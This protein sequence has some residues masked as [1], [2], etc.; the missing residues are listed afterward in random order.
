MTVYCKKSVGY[1]HLKNDPSVRHNL[2]TGDDLSPDSA[3]SNSLRQ[4]N[5]VNSNPKL[6][7]N[8]ASN[9]LNLLKAYLQSYSTRMIHNQ[10]TIPAH[11]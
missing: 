5:D 1:Y 6:P 10:L 3:V 9:S 2:L 7:C 4:A 11:E 8:T